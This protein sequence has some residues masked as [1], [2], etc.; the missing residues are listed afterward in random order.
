MKPYFA[1]LGIRASDGDVAVGS[2]KA[3]GK[4]RRFSLIAAFA[5]SCCVATQVSNAQLTILHSF[6][7]GTVP[8][9]GAYPFAGLIQAP[10]GDF[11]GTTSTSA[12]KV[13]FNLSNGT[14]FRM[15]SAGTV[16]I[17]RAFSP[18]SKMG[19]TEALLY[20]NG[21]LFG[22]TST[23]TGKKAG[24][25][26][27]TKS[28]GTTAILHVFDLVN[29]P[30]DGGSPEASLI[31]GSDGYLYGTTELGGSSSKGTIFRLKPTSPYHLT[32]LYS[33]GSEGGVPKAA[34]L[35]ANDGNYY[36]TTFR[37]AGGNGG[38]IF[39]MTPAGQVTILY[40][41][42]NVAGN[43]GPSSPLIQGS[44]GN[45]YGTTE[46]A[47]QYNLGSVFKMTQDF[48]V[49]TLHSF[50]NGTDGFIANGALVQGP[51]GNLYGMT[52]RGGS[53]EVGTIYEIST[54]GSSYTILHNFGD[55][56]VPNDGNSPNGALVVGSDNNLYGTTQ[57]GG[58]ANLGTVFK[59]SP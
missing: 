49:T 4:D 48:N 21:E 12:G 19:P 5:L 15:T 8:N 20:Y 7:D 35:L 40:Q 30:Q 13:T 43:E 53:A 29:A 34:L 16:E 31:L 37:G 55:G 39:Q 42:P 18:A 44:D 14:V 22:T 23:G 28:S 47:G 36:G 41:F 27:R 51:N 11:Y 38:T 56:S 17:I 45:F 54:D 32:S 10:D 25:V 59:I 1:T 46:A 6:G 58:S 2:V 24:T 50:G 3:K 26:F 33:F 9:D 52:V 57:A